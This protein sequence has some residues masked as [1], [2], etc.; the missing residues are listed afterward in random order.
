MSSRKP[1]LK[2]RAMAAVIGGNPS[3]A[4]LSPTPFPVTPKTGP[5]ALIA[6]LAR[7][8]D[9]QRENDHLRDELKSWEG[10]SPVRRLDPSSVV[11]SRWSNRHDDTYK[12]AEFEA[13]KQEIAAAGGNVQPVKVRPITTG[14]NVGCF[15]IVFG[16]RRHRACLELG[17][18][19][20]SLVESIDEQTLFA[21]MDR[22]NRQRVDL[23]PYEQGEMYRRAL[24]EKL[25]P[26]L[27]SMAEALGVDPGN[28][29]KAVS[30]ASLPTEVLDAFPSRLDLQYRWAST[31]SKLIDKEKDQVMSRARMV[32]KDRLDGV[33]LSPSEVFERL[34]GKANVGDASILE[35]FSS[36]G[37]K[38]SWKEA[39]GKQV[40]E[41]DSLALTLDARRQLEQIIRQLIV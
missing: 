40:I 26:S 36:S 25:F 4:N 7:E 13:L 20:L 32:V 1:S 15:E 41:I 2:D 17:L 22:E 12:S 14:T 27:R 9:A 34:C 6:H 21:E 23:R 28:V 39:R 29:S 24:E 19:L 11:V 10:A 31:L 3:H 37:K 18:P 38:V 5:G 8:S 30:L 35:F 16:H 33:H